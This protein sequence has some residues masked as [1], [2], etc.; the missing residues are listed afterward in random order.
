MKG[1]SRKKV[2]ALPD[3]AEHCLS[4]LAILVQAPGSRGPW[5]GLARALVWTF[6]PGKD[7]GTTLFANDPE[8]H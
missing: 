6:Q 5:T 7:G 3:Q 4:R 2:K 1:W 8:E